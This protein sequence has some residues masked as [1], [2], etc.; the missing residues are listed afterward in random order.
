M[1]IIWQINPEDVARVQAFFDRYRDD[2]LVRERY[3]INLRDDKP[4]VT[5]S[6]A[7]ER[8]ICCLLTSQQR[9]G[10]GKP[11]SRFVEEE[12]FALRYSLCIEQPNFGQR[13]NRIDLLVPIET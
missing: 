2:D 4:P 13:L 1:N 8:M 5:K 11:V 3:E 9:S 10:P 12:P 6:A 7:W